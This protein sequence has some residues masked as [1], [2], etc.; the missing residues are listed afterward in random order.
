MESIKIPYILWEYDPEICRQQLKDKWKDP[1]WNAACLAKHPKNYFKNQTVVIPITIATA[2][3]GFKIE[4]M[5]IYL[6]GEKLLILSVLDKAS[7][8]QLPGLGRI[9]SRI[10]L[11]RPCEMPPGIG[12]DFMHFIINPGH[13]S[14]KD[15]N[16]LS[17]MQICYV[18]DEEEFCRHLNFC[19]RAPDYLKDLRH[20]L[21]DQKY[22]QDGAS[23]SEEET[24]VAAPA[25]QSWTAQW[26]KPI[27]RMFGV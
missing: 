3:K 8:K 10:I 17:E 4:C 9:R 6:I 1:V 20:H 2:S 23:S 14:Y 25:S 11:K 18:K 12:Y 27:L 16:T 5:K 22:N 24:P 13:D 15:L 21:I 7:T 26:I 19:T